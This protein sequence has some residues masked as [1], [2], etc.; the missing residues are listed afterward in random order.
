MPTGLRLLL[1]LCVLLLPAA[2]PAEVRDDANTPAANAVVSLGRCTGTLI[3][4]RIILTAAHCLPSGLRV[5]ATASVPERCARFPQQHEISKEPHENPFAWTTFPTRAA[6]VARFG[7]DSASRRISMKAEA[8]SLPACADMA[9]LRLSHDVPS[10]VAT[11]LPVLVTGPEGLPPPWRD[12]PL[13]HAGW[14]AASVEELDGAVRQTGTVR[15]WTENACTLF[16][17]PPVRPNGA[18]ILTGDSGSPLL[19]MLETPQ[20]PQEHVIAV[21]FASGAP[22]IATCGPPALRVPQRHGAYTAT[23]RKALP[24]S[25]ATDLGAW[26]THHAPDAVRTWPDLTP[27]PG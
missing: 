18:R 25:D 13:R 5:D 6:P 12:F 15:P 1:A 8:Y 26:L 20:G 16:A 14:G 21:L 2:A 19:A 23:W 10:A 3:T 24:E 9:L 7:T 4:P 11:P 27:P 17:L 22:D